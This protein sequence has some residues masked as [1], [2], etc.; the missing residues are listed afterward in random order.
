MLGNAGSSSGVRKGLNKS[1]GDF[2]H[3]IM[4]LLDLEEG[5]RSRPG[6]FSLLGIAGGVS[7]EKLVTRGLANYLPI[8]S[9]LFVFIQKGHAHSLLAAHH[10]RVEN[11]RVG[12]LGR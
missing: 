7:R 2:I 11:L 1:M 8:G 3:F 6:A 4:S 12:V 10:C 9:R 5:R